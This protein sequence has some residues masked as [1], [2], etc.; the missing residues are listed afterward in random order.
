MGLRVLQISQ[1]NFK[2]EYYDEGFCRVFESIKIYYFEK[3]F[4]APK[5]IK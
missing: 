1:N 4:I 2:G 3:E 5:P